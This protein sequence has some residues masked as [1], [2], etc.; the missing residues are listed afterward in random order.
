MR[1]KHIIFFVLA[2]GISLLGATYRWGDSGHSI[3]LIESSGGKVRHP[4]FLKSGKNRY[5]LISTATVI[6]PYRG[7]ARLVVEGKP[8]MDREI[9]V[10][11]PV[12]DLGLRRLPKFRDNVL[13]GL[14]PRDRLAVWVVMKPPVVDPVCGMAYQEGFIKHTYGGKDY[15]FCSE[16]CLSS[17]KKE[18]ERYKDRDSVRGKYALAFYDTK[19]A[20]SI[21]RV[22]M[23]FI[24]KGDTEYAHRH[25]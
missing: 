25:H 2:V 17:F 11:A 1:L 4:T 18:P 21:L 7:D 14:E 16:R 22:P 8:E 6:P 24:G 20:K 13:Y 3:G 19:T 12:V 15:Y 10:S 9:Y 23:I 5:V